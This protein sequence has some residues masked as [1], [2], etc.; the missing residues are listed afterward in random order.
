MTKKEI[1]TI[2][3]FGNSH[4]IPIPGLPLGVSKF[5]VFL[6]IKPLLED[7]QYWYALSEAY[8]M[9]DNLY[10][11]REDVRL[12]FSSPYHGREYLMN[13]K[14]RKYME[15]LPEEFTIYRGMSEA[16]FKSGNFGLSWTLKKD[17]A[18]FFANEYQ[19]N[20]ATRKDRKVV[21]E[22]VIHK[23]DVI[24]FFNGRKEFEIIYLP[25]SEQGLFRA[26]RGL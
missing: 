24:A 5:Q 2:I 13:S 20:Y 21:H 11:Y 18:Q 1:D 25:L 16:E 12:A 8:C 14:E 22:M 6:S 19:R 9:S 10:Q 26:Q 17:E 4:I 3:G 23:K 7:K 15:K